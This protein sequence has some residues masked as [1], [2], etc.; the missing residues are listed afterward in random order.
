MVFDTTLFLCGT[1]GLWCRY[2]A[3]GAGRSTYG[4]ESDATLFVLTRESWCL[5]L[6]STKKQYAVF[7]S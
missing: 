3:I 6:P 4:D 7:L 5:K 1:V 2:H